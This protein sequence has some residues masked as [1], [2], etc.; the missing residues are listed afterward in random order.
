MGDRGMRLWQFMETRSRK[1][2]KSTM[3]KL[4]VG[5]ACLARLNFDGDYANRLLEQS[6]EQLD[7]LDVDLIHR[8]ELTVTEEDAKSIANYFNEE[9]ADVAVIQ[10]GTFSLGTLMPILA[11]ELSV[12]IILWGVPE[13]SLNGRLRSNSFCGINMNAHTLMRLQRPYDYIFC[14][15][16]EA[17]GE[18]E[19]LLRAL[20][21][22]KQVRQIRVGLVGYRVPGF[23]TSTFDEL[24]LRRQL[25]VEVHHIT[26]AEVF[27][28]AQKVDETSRMREA[29]AI[30][31]EAGAS[32]IT[33]EELDKA[34][35][36]F[37]GFKNL[38]EKYNLDTLAVK[39]W[40]EFA[41]SYGIA[42]CSTLGRLNDAGI[43]TSCEGDVYGVVTMTIAH[44]LSGKTPM[45]ADFVAVN[46]QKNT[47]VAW[48]CGAA[49]VSLAA[50]RAQVKLCKHSVVDGGGK[51]GVT[52]EFP[53]RDEGAVTMVQLSVGRDGLRLF[54]AGG[55]AVKMDSLLCGNP[56]NVRFDCPISQLTKS[57]VEE[58]LEHHYSMVHADIRTELRRLAKWLDIETVDMDS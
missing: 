24:G 5:Y 20:H 26:L 44:V 45:F 38:V 19:P 9:K 36:L 17:P 35:A 2:L 43:L 57:I 31:S 3:T 32:E 22:I 15:P 6:V 33:E 52:V 41:S 46:E 51:K 50:D 14:M 58:G 1:R 55:E 25:G 30:R 23:Y 28:E 29:E 12:P 34:A 7:S 48:H 54:F 18:L 47:G 37:L 8:S 39:C 13:P 4:R 56:L 21:C 11:Q 42:V 53:V 16:E 10:Y 49:P 27:E 40:P